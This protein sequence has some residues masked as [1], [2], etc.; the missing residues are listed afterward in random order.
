MIGGH[1]IYQS[2]TFPEC[3]PGQPGTERLH[4]IS[5]NQVNWIQ[6]IYS[7]LS[8]GRPYVFSPLPY[9]LRVKPDSCRFPELSKA[10][11]GHAP[12]PGML[13]APD[14]AVAQPSTW[15]GTESRGTAPP[16]QSHPGWPVIPYIFRVQ[17]KTP[18]T[19]HLTL[20]LVSPSAGSSLYIVSSLPSAPTPFP[21]CPIS[22]DLLVF[23]G[24]L[25]AFRLH[26]WGPARR[27]REVG[28]HSWSGATLLNSLT[29]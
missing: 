15:K 25:R 8:P 28:G 1:R 4:T 24:E 11:K 19:D 13:H 7:D 23:L 10:K 17:S 18:A 29:S 27:S 21:Y 6:S 3:K 26:P 20:Y 9:S 14:V 16:I 2:P 5:G 22:S 12:G